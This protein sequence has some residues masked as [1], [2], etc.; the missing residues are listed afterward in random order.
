M[1]TEEPVIA[2]GAPADQSVP[3]GAAESQKPKA[4]VKK[5]TRPDDVAQKAKIEEFQSVSKCLM[6]SFCGSCWD[7]SR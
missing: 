5:P 1:S 2:E 7:G 4:R 6:F 3:A